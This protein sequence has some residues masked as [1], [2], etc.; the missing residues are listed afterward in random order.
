MVAYNGIVYVAAGG[1]VT[2]LDAKTLKQV[3]TGTYSRGP[4]PGRGPR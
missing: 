2:A 1:K 4:A 3:A